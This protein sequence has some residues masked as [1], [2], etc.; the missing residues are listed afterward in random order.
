[1]ASKKHPQAQLEDRRTQLQKDIE[2]FLAK[3]GHIDQVESGLSGDKSAP[4]HSLQGQRPNTQVR[5][6]SPISYGSFQSIEIF[7]KTKR[8]T[9]C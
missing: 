6:H 7:G 5:I 9:I 1:M 2:A 3:G 8:A 4:A